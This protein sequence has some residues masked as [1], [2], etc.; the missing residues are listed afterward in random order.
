MKKIFLS[1]IPLLLCYWSFAQ[2]YSGTVICPNGN[3]PVS[4]V[5][6][7][8]PGK[9]VGTTSDQHGKF[10]IQLSDCYNNDSILFSCIGFKPLNI[11]VGDFKSKTA[12]EVYLNEEIAE[13]DEVVIFPKK[14]KRKSFGIKTHSKAV[15]AGFCN[16]D[17]GYE[18]GIMIRNKGAIKIEKIAMNIGK[19][20]FDTI[21]YRV[22]V[23]KVHGKND[24]ENII[25]SPIY[26][27]FPRSSIAETITLDLSNRNIWVDGNC[28]LTLEHVR[29]A[30]DGVLDFCSVL[31]ARTYYRKTSQG[32]WDSVPIGI[33]LSVDALVER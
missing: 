28:V 10:N 27:T 8:I 22:N 15:M 12:T 29:N 33:S 3:F 11:N 24:F 26:L 1:L 21:F 19:C 17:L 7:G 14:L 30:G 4:Y 32:E 31:G 20:T 5:N 9:N 18:M 13:L 23:Y 6:I 2:V 25:T 16:N